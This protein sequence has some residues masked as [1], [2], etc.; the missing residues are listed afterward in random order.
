MLLSLLGSVIAVPIFLLIAFAI[1]IEDGGDIFFLQDRVGRDGILFKIV[2]FRTMRARGPQ[3][4]PLLTVSGDRRVTKVGRVLRSSKLDELPQLWNVLCGDMS[5]VG[6]RPE[7]PMYV[8]S[9]TES[10]RRVLTLTPGITDEASLAFRDEERLL[11]SVPDA[12]LYYR[13]FCIPRKIELNLEYARRANIKTDL[14]LILR[15][16]A[17]MFRSS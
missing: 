3:G 2:K 17:S 10:Q 5:L 15:S 14:L 16:I 4:G 8:A 6:P 1:R 11:K 9:Y 7:V 13:Q 12:D